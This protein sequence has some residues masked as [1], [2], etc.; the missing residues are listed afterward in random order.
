MEKSPALDASTLAELKE[1]SDQTDPTLVSDLIRLFFETVPPKLSQVEALINQSRYE[2]LTCEQISFQAHSIKS[3]AANLGAKTMAQ[4]CQEL[5]TASRP[6]QT[7]S[8]SPELGKPLFEKI[9]REFS[10]VEAELKQWQ[11][12]WG[13]AA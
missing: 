13:K 2:K 7:A 5:E 10:C 6:A 11:E 4:F 8:F 1:L 3:S 12:K 9:K